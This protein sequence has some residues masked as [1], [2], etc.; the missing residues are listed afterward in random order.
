METKVVEF[1]QQA[2][3][4]PPMAAQCPIEAVYATRSIRL[5]SAPDDRVGEIISSYVKDNRP[6]PILV[7]FWSTKAKFGEP[8]DVAEL[9]TIRQLRHLQDRVAACYKP[10]CELVVRAEDTSGL[11][12]FADQA[13]IQ[14]STALYCNSLQQLCSEFG[15]T[16]LRESQMEKAGLF[17]DAAWKYAAMIHDYLRESDPVSFLNVARAATMPTYQRLLDEGWKGIIEWEQRNHHY[18]AYKR[19]HDDND[20]M[21]QH[22][23]AIYLA[24]AMTR[25]K[26][27]MVGTKP[28]WDK[29]FVCLSFA[30]PVPGIPAE[31]ASNYVYYRTLPTCF[32]KT[33]IPTWR[34]KGYINKAIIPKVCNWREPIKYVEHNVIIGNVQ[35]SA[36]Y[37]GE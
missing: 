14:E 33:H 36:D 13:N 7:P 22:R 5:G 29:G 28:E 16:L 8:I 9:F 35:V 32:C 31:L 17:N 30:L 20:D 10:G 27:N 2:M 4:E 12:L 3:R 23:L 24:C 34:A 11:C 15:V 25:R 6:I 21:R 37:E 26:L 18:A 1:L 19:L